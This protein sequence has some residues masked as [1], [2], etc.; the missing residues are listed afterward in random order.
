MMQTDTPKPAFWRS[1][2]LFEGADNAT[3]TRL[4]AAAI[5]RDWPAGALL[6]QRGDEGDYLVAIRTGRVRLSLGS[7]QGRE[8]TLRHAAPG[9]LLGELALFDAAPRSADA[10]AAVATS[11]YVLH[12]ADFLALAA[13]SPALMQSVTRHLC[14]RL[15]ETTDQ[16]EGIAL[17]PLDARLARFLLFTLRQIHG[18][19]IPPDPS[20]RLDITQG[21]LAAVLGASRP[22]VNRALQALRD[23]GAVVRQDEGLRCHVER[24]TRLAEPLAE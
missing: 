21:E 11:G 8:L 10:V 3:L 12:R 4:A 23:A 22:K 14:T 2:A 19:D 24:L 16:L 20:L 1:F 13:Q 9:D 6:F 18:D 17:Y 5:R 7:A 15:R